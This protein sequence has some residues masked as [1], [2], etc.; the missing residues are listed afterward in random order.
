MS[1][2]AG[3]RRK[4][5]RQRIEERR[6]TAG[7]LESGL[8][9]NLDAA[10]NF[11]LALVGEVVFPWDTDYD[12]DRQESNP[13]FQRYP[14]MIVYCEVENDIRLSLAFAKRYGL[15]VAARSGGHSTAGYSVNDGGMVIDTSRIKYVHVDKTSMTAVVGA[16]TNFGFL[17][18]KLDAHQV[19]VPGGA[20]EDVC[21]AGYM[22]GGGFG[23]TS[24]NFGMN[25]DNVLS[26]RMMLR[27][28]GIVNASPEENSDLFWAVRGGTGGNFG[29]LLEITYRVHPLSHL[30]GFALIWDSRNAAEVMTV[31]QNHYTKTGASQKLG[32]MG[33]IATHDG[34]PIFALQGMFVGDRENGLAELQRLR[35]VGNPD[36]AVDITL[37]YGQLDLY[38]DGH[39]YPIPQLPPGNV[40][41]VKQACY[42]SRMLSGGDWKKILDYYTSEPP[43]LS[44]NTAVIEG[45]GGAIN[46]RSPFFNAFIHRDATMDFFVDAFWV[47]DE[48]ESDAVEWLDGYMKVLEPY[49]NGHVYQN[50]P[51]NTLQDYRWNYWGDAFPTLLAVKN[52]YDPPPYF[53]HYQQSIKPYGE[54]EHPPPQTGT[55]SANQR[56]GF[57]DDAIRHPITYCG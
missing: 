15:W 12:R 28:G 19:H 8:P 7:N 4:L 21:V 18:A 57:L 34:K 10:A 20:C 50:Y 5:K 43:P 3:M 26:F 54:G 49:Q 51:R 53:F 30:W 35:E 42:I 55:K 31:L 16:G 27:D 22:Q 25:C 23:Y 17:N 40:K 56:P 9:Y 41:E 2:K 38:L 47:G 44:A 46:A 1:L 36:L 39:P 6:N 48:G 24:R 14:I 52:K 11:E 13:A 29:I 33:N 37:P 45:Y 32:Y